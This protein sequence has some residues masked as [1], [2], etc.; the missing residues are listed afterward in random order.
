MVGYSYWCSTDGKYAIVCFEDAIGNYAGCC[1][2]RLSQMSYGAES[3]GPEYFRQV[4]APGRTFIDVFE[5]TNPRNVDAML[6]ELIQKR[7][8]KPRL[9]PEDLVWLR[10]MRIG[11]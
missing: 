11:L 7:R 9:T 4:F 2:V 6:D 5:P 1:L 3:D 8:G 10:E